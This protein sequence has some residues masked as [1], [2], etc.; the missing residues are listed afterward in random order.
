LLKDFIQNHPERRA[1]F[2]ELPNA[3]IEPVSREWTQAYVDI[4]AELQKIFLQKIS[5]E[6]GYKELG[7]KLRSYIH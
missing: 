1:G 3:L 6:D 2:D 7:Q 5:P 4:G